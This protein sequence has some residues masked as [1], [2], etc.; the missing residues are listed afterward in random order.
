MLV[1]I[2][3]LLTLA[4][5]APPEAPEDLSELTLYLFEHFDSEGEE[6]AAGVPVMRDFLLAVDPEW[7]VED[8]AVTLPALEE[9]SLGGAPATPGAEPA[10]QVPVAVMWTSRQ[11]IEP[12]FALSVDPNQVCIDSESSVYHHRTFITDPDCFEDGSCKVLETVA[13]I[14]REEAIAN[15]W[16]DYYSDVRRVDVD[17][18]EA[19]VSRGWLPEFAYSDGAE[20]IFHQSYMLD[21][22]MAHPDDASKTLRFYGIWSSLEMTGVTD[23]LYSILIR[24]GIQDSFD[25]ADDFADGILC[26]NDRD[27]EPERE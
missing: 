5:E 9:A 22:R 21:V 11:A 15:F 1:M 17:G 6:L 12:H 13:E 7:D 14:R 19:L 10:L 26:D 23:D 4:C 8:R 2:P 25:L 24:N 16:Y 20:A 18:E 27:H 3:L